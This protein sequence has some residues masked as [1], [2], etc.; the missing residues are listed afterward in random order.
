V[1]ICLNDT[2]GDGD[3]AACARNPKAPCRVSARDKLWELYQ[4]PDTASAFGEALDA[5]A[6]ELAEK[7]MALRATVPGLKARQLFKDGYDAALMV[8]A[9]EIDPEVSSGS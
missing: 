1:S 7:V 4:T 8:A 5:Y 3:C 6:H 2:N 9:L